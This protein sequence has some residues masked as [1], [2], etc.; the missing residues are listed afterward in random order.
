[1]NNR[2][3]RRGMTARKGKLQLYKT[4]RQELIEFKKVSINL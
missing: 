2:E 4:G 1:M 3:Y